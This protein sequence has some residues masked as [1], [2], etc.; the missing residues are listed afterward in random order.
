MPKGTFIVIDGTDGSGKTVQ[1]NKLIERLQAEGRRVTK[2]DFPQY[3]KLSARLVEQYL[4]GEFGGANDVGP[5]VASAFYALDRFD[6]A[7]EIRKAIE[8]GGIA[9]SNRYASSNKGHQLGKIEDPEEQRKFLDWLNE[10]EYG[11]NGIP[12]PD[13]TIFLH[14]PAEIGFELAKKRDAASDGTEKKDIHQADITHLKNAERAFLRAVEID[15][16]ENWKVVEC[17]KDGALLPIDEIHE[18][19]RETVSPLL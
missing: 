3:G 16:G 7:P 15:T 5:K 14:A 6:A 18:K 12:K 4:A 11:K 1:T 19:I 8:D 9:I 10:L 17:A 13:L 2:F